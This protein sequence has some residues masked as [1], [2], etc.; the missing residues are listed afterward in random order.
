MPPADA[1]RW[2]PEWLKRPGFK[3]QG[4]FGF[5][6]TVARKRKFAGNVMSKNTIGM[7]RPGRS[8]VS[9]RQ[10]SSLNDRAHQ[11]NIHPEGL[12]AGVGGGCGRCY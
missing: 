4:L 12:P 2:D 9:A 10:P 5:A 8:W 3:W 1:V 7:N 6:M 11:L